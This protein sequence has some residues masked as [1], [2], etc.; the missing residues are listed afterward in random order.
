RKNSY[1]LPCRVLVPDLVTTLTTEPELRPYS[2]S[3]VL[4]RTRNS[5]MQSGQGC[6]VGKFTNASLASP[7]FT[8]KL[9]ERP[10]PPFTDT[11]P[12]LLLP[13]TIELLDPTVDITPGCNCKN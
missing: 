3:K 7:P 12:E 1:T 10:R 4:V 8:L 13:Y 2:A 11:A 6:T 5:W 9:L